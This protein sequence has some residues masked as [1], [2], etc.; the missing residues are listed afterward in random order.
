MKN[1]LRNLCFNIVGGLIASLMILAIQRW[2][3]SLIH[4]ALYMMSTLIH[5]TPYMISAACGAAL[6]PILT[7]T[8]RLVRR[9]SGMI[10]S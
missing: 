2:H 9:R 7:I 4:F 1:D 8:M 5:F 10:Q 3:D 6:V